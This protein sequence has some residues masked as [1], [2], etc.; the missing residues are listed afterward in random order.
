MS[1]ANDG[2]FDRIDLWQLDARRD[3]FLVYHGEGEDRVQAASGVIQAEGSQD[4]DLVL[5]S[6]DLVPALFEGLLTFNHNATGGETIL[7]VRLEVIGPRRPEQFTLINPPDSMVI[8]ANQDNVEI[9]F[10]WQRAVDYNADDVVSYLLWYKSGEDSTMIE[11]AET[12][13][14]LNLLQMLDRLGHSIEVEWPLEWWVWAISGEDTVE[15]LD[16]FSLFFLPNAVGDPSI[17]PP[18]EFGLQSIYPSP[19]NASTTIRF[20]VDRVEPVKLRIFDT[21]GRLV[22][23]LADGKLK[24]GWHQVAWN[25]AEIPSGVYIVRLDAAGRNQSLKTALI[26]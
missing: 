25:A 11:A 26:R 24:T 4:F 5:S 19:F 20:G 16:R 17:L 18:V 3:W 21:Q 7:N 8:D 14:G 12:I 6:E 22:R 10:A 13:V 15:S 2:E 1:I 23:T 9:A